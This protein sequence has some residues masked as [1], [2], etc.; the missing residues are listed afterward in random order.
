MTIDFLG[1]LAGV[2]FI[3]FMFWAGLKSG[4]KG[5]KADEK[6]PGKKKAAK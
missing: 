3:A 6:K 1:F 2:L 4:K 5:P